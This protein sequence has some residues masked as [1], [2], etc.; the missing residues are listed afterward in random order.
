MANNKLG[1]EIAR[2][3][4]ERESPVALV[5]HPPHRARFRDEIV[6]ACGLP[7]D[8]VFDGATFQHPEER[9]RLAALSPE[10]GVSI[11]FDYV[12]RGETLA[13]FPRGCIN[14]HP[15]LLPYN[16]GQYPNVWSIVE[17]TPSGVTLHY[18][19]E[20]VDTGDLV[21]QREVPVSSTDTGESLYR[22]LEAAGLDLFRETWP[23][24][25]RG[26]VPRLAQP[27]DGG[28]TYHRTRDVDAID[29][30]ELDRSYT[31]RQLIDVL[32]ART[33]PPYRGAYFEEHGR[34]IYLR[35]S[36]EPDEAG[37]KEGGADA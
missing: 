32:R 16:R 34:R 35:L 9:A 14:L 5:V 33:F 30:I 20:G 37:V 15:S 26:T 6:A 7:Q 8:R 28:G 3:L 18:M 2:W 29:R 13:L 25:E 4:S 36:L 23:A 17:G 31:A 1:L 21:A 19:D 10:V 24:V 22:K 27:R 12:L 11:L